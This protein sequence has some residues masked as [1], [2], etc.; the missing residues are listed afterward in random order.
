MPLIR[1]QD[2][3]V[4]N[5]H[6]WCISVSQKAPSLVFEILKQELKVNKQNEQK[7]LNNKMLVSDSFAAYSDLDYFRIFWHPKI[8]TEKKISFNQW[9]VAEHLK[10]I[11][12]FAG[13]GI[14]K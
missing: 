1:S 2:E 13:I 4:L 10:N 3:Q 9:H 12:L 11:I 7:L 5:H 14:K 6:D 8:L